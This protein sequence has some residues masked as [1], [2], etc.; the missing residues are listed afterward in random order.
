MFLLFIL[1]IAKDIDAKCYSCDG[2]ILINVTDTSHELRISSQCEVINDSCFFNLSTLTAFTFQNN[3][4]LIIIGNHSFEK[5]L[6]LQSIDLSS[7]TK[8]VKIKTN[9]F[10][11]CSL[12]NQ[13]LL[14]R[15]LIEID[16]FAFSGTAITSISIPATV[17]VIG[18]NAF[19]S[20]LSLN[21]VTF[22]DGSNLEKIQSDT[23]TYSGIKTFQ[24]PE[25]VQSVDGSFLQN[26]PV[27][28]ITIHPSNHYLKISNGVIYSS[29]QTIL[30]MVYSKQITNFVVP[31]FVTRLCSDCFS[32]SKIIN[33]TIPS[34]V[35]IIDNDVFMFTTVE[36]LIFSEPFEYFNFGSLFMSSVKWI[37]FPPTSM[38]I[39]YSI[40]SVFRV[41]PM[42]FLS[43]IF[44]YPGSIPYTI[45]VTVSY[46]SEN[47][48]VITNDAL[49]MNFEQTTIFEFWGYNYKNNLDGVKIPK[50]VT[51][52]N[53][54]AF[55]SS[56]ILKIQFDQNSELLTIGNNSFNNCTLL[57]SLVFPSKL[58]SIGNYAFKDCSKLICIT[59]LSNHFIVEDNSF[60]NCN[61]LMNIYNMTNVPNFIFAGFNKLTVVTL[62]N[63]AESIGNCSFE[64]CTSL[65]MV[66]I[67]SSI[68]SISDNAFRNCIQLQIIAFPSI[69][70]L[71]V[72]SVSSVDG[73]LSLTN[74]SDF[75]S[76]KY[77][78]INNTI[79]MVS[80]GA[81][82]TALY[83]R[84]LKEIYADYKYIIKNMNIC[85]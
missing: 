69:C 80:K 57:Q 1:N 6:N 8:L 66:N 3:P 63:G 45:N 38:I 70:S 54:K 33:V 60:E 76:N 15:G 25:N 16:S 26:T 37:T 50:T 27:E 74:I 84:L 67:S 20:S 30:M 18:F 10:S 17:K 39:N 68:K 46:I 47:N 21:T 43:K 48:L 83:M 75:Q 78:C 53:D 64:N 11:T 5:C 34:S 44:F 32:S 29:N 2:K 79:Y 42:H 77:K 31:S 85:I 59:F 62:Q 55:E 61:E 82:S 49:I 73:C 14:P 13:I 9:A 51:K 7:C 58:S 22:V 12:V 56:D 19:S 41:Y 72:F 24:I 81:F 36:N 52:I 4:N 23:F 35:K 40:S 65:L 71:E 28:S